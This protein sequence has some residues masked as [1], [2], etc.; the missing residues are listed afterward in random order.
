MQPGY[1]KLSAHAY[2]HFRIYIELAEQYGKM[3]PASNVLKRHVLADHL[4]EVIE[5]LEEKGDQI[6]SLYDLLS[7]KDKPD[8]AVP[9]LSRRNPR[10]R[11]TINARRREG[12]GGVPIDAKA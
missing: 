11:H 5:T 3:D 2:I 6:A 10:A 9:L 1:P 7:F 8:A 4:R 12:A